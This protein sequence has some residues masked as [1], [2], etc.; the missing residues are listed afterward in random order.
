MIVALRLAAKIEGLAFRCFRSRKVTR[1][2]QCTR[3]IV[4][5]GGV[6]WTIGTIN[7]ALVRDRL[8]QKLQGFW[9]LAF[10]LKQ[11]RQVVS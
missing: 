6:A 3:Q 4:E 10:A 9:I 7:P 8:S 1:I 2:D 11:K 5:T